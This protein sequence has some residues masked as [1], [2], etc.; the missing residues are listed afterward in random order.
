MRLARRKFLRLA[1]GAA[2]LPAVSHVAEAQ[3]YPSRPITMIKVRGWRSRRCGCK[4]IGRA[5]EKVARASH[6]DAIEHWLFELSK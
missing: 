5:N 1:A 2:A 6:L 3:A 4:T